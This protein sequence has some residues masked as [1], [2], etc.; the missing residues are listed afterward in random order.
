M[1]RRTL[2]IV[3]LCVALL[4]AVLAFHAWLDSHDDQLR[5]QSTIASQKQILDAADARE[6]DRNSSLNVTLA[7]IE[8]LKRQAQSETPEQILRELPKYLELPQPITMSST[9]TASGDKGTAPISPPAAAPAASS[10]SENQQGTSATAKQGTESP[11]E[12]FLHSLTRSSGRGDSASSTVPQS[13]TISAS[14]Q[15]PSS[16]PNPDVPK[17]DPN[18]DSQSG[19]PP[20]PRQSSS[21]SPAPS[22]PSAEIPAADIKPLYDFVQDCRACQAQL[23]AAKQTAS[24]TALKLTAVTRERDAALTAAKGGSFWLRLR[25]NAHWLVIGAGIS[26]AALCGS[27][28]CR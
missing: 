5:L 28:H 20:T 11:F 27:G 7:Q 2:E 4:I 8:A 18:D 16:S 13:P 3:A 15:V 22:N 21:P 9:P 1:T 26:A 10:T 23:S 24:D 17:S 25:R 14:A 19:T 6:R 12:S